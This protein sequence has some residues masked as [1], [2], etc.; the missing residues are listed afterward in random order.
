M[1]STDINTVVFGKCR[2]RRKQP[3]NQPRTR[4]TRRTRSTRLSDGRTVLTT[5][6]PKPN[7]EPQTEPNRYR[8]RNP[9]GGHKTQTVDRVATQ[10]RVS[11][12]G[13]VGRTPEGRLAMVG[14]KTGTAVSGHRVTDGTATAT[15]R[16]HEKAL[17]T[18]GRGRRAQSGRRGGISGVPRAPDLSGVTAPAT[19]EQRALHARYHANKNDRSMMV[20]HPRQRRT[21]AQ[22]MAD[23]DAIRARESL[24]WDNERGIDRYLDI[25]GESILDTSEITYRIL[26]A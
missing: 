18:Q 9:Q 5:V 19:P 26:G 15:R 24:A 4:R 23:A 17:Q 10:A 22:R 16:I 20:D 13:L 1:K 3:T 14:M 21:K 12:R 25:Y 11:H 8:T 6:A 7:P 2:T